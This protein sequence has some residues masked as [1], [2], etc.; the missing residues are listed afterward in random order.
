VTSILTPQQLNDL[1]AFQKT[2]RS[3]PSSHNERVIS[4]GASNLSRRVLQFGNPKR[5]ARDR[6]I[7]RF[8]PLK[9]QLRAPRG[10][11][12]PAKDG[13]RLLA[14]PAQGEQMAM[15]RPHARP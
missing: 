4:A 15:P 8:Q 9:G 12:A 2:S 1:V 10:P 13:G 14:R 11:L 6:T 3:P 7:G 5:L